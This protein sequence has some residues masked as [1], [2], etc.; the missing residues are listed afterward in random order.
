M[1]I[2]IK[3]KIGRGL[4]W[5]VALIVGLVLAIAVIAIPLWLLPGHFQID[6]VNSR[7]IRTIGTGIIVAILTW[8]L[9]PINQDIRFSF[10]VAKKFVWLFVT[11][12]ALVFWPIVF[13]IWFNSYNIKSH[14]IHDMVVVDILSTNLRSGTTPMKTFKV[15]EISTGWEADLAFS[16]E[17]K[18]FAMP[19]NCVR[20]FVQ[21][22][23]LG[24]DWI[25]NAL[26]IKCPTSTEYSPIH[27]Q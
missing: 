21:Q 12:S 23:R 19:G 18:N 4:G 25:E 20:I 22:G 6:F 16:D 10:P 11:G 8:R 24:L 7:W 1:F 5:I 15:R 2:D 14:T 3:A 27:T 13:S 26:P 17:R 9:S